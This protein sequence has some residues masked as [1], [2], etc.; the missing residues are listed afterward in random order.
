NSKPAAWPHS[1][2][3]V[4]VPLIACFLWEGEENDK[5]WLATMQHALDDIKV[6]A[7]R[8]GCI[9]EDSPAYPI[10]D[11]GTTDAEVVY[12]ENIDKLIAIRKKYD[13]DNV[14]GLTGGL[15]I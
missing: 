10:L 5:F 8:E 9:Y 2:D 13:P 14:M 1:R 12:R 3:R 4:V 6:V 15:K 7:R 11:F